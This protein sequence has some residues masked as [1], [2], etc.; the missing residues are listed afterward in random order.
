MHSNDIVVIA[1]TSN[2]PL[3]KKMESYI[4]KQKYWGGFK[5]CDRL[6]KTFSDRETKIE[7]H[8]N[9]RNKR[10]YILQSSCPPATDHFIMELYLSLR[11]CHRASAGKMSAVFPYFGYS[12]QDKKVIPRVPIS[13]RDICDLIQLGG[14]KSI[15]G[16][17]LH[18]GQIQGFFD[19]PF[20]NI[21]VKPILVNYIKKNFPDN[22]FIIISPDHGGV[23]RTRAYAKKLGAPLAIIHK[24]RDSE[25]NL[26]EMEL[27]QGKEGVRGRNCILIDDIADTFGTMAKAINL[28]IKERAG[29]I[30]AVVTHPVL[31]GNA[32]KNL[33]ESDIEKLIVTDT[34]PLSEN[35]K[36]C[37]KIET[38]SI[39]PL[40]AQAIMLDYE[41]KSISQLFDD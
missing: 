3:F 16:M 23:E 25:G 2:P 26:I 5:L 39:A 37:N 14:A 9:I 27:I 35:A 19:G 17:D 18:C 38:V 1:G 21:F 29:K 32:I 4:A 15:I 8:E 28:L 31:S 40:L 20:E 36:N 34:I 33:N 10:T 7:I 41:G 30:Y 24:R 22:N 6:M 12:R 13:A 11:T